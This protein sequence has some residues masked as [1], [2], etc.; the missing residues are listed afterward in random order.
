MVPLDPAAARFA[1]SWLGAPEGPGL[2]AL[3]H[4]LAYRRPGL[5]GDRPGSPRSVVLVREG[6]GGLEA[7]GAGEAEP[8]VGWLVGHLRAFTL[9]AP[10]DWLDAVTA[11]LAGVEFEEVETWSGPRDAAAGPVATRRLTFVDA[12]AF[13]RSAPTW[14]L[15]GWRTYP[16]LVTHGVAFG[17]PHGQG[18]AALAW[19]FDQ[20]DPYAALGTYTAPR[21]RRLGLGRAAASALVRHLVER[22]GKIPLWS[23]PVRNAPSRALAESLGFS[24]RTT[25]TLARWSPKIGDE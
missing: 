4:A 3:R 13:A 12:E 25:E 1:R 11:R 19:V 2:L 20:A 16:E 9:Q 10:D 18:F 14:G 21:Y 17:V 7:F 15:R 5:W 8:A 23:T 22:R 6:D 24:P